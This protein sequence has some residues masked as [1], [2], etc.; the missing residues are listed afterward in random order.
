[1]AWVV[2]DLLVPVN[3][4]VIP[5]LSLLHPTPHPSLPFPPPPVSARACVCFSGDIL[6]SVNDKTMTRLAGVCACAR[7]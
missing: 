4:L 1:M 3:D 6:V 2:C 5:R 7:A